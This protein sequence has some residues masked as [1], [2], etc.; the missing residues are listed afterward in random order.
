MTRA[1]LT[2][3]G[4]KKFTVIRPSEAGTR[5]PAT[6]E[7][8]PAVPQ[9]LEILGNEQPLPGSE[10]QL[11][12]ESLRQKDTRKFFCISPIYAL[13]QAETK[14]ADHI[15]IDGYEFEVYKVAK[16]QM[17]VRDHYEATLIRTEQSAGMNNG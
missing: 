10:K 17:G 7:W 5:D 16:Y 11:L 14:Q 9:Q 12:P 3:V 4:R 2:K 6:G 1:L 13:D 8:I 15:I